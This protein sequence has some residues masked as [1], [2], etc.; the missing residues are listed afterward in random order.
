MAAS[1]VHRIAE[2]DR[3]EHV[4]REYSYRGGALAQREV[5]VR[6]P[7]WSRTGADDHSVEGKVRAWQPILERGGTLIGAFEAEALAG[8]AIYRPR[9]MDDMGNL[10][11]LHV[12]RNHRRKGVASRLAEEV[13]RLARADGALRLY[14]SAT[15]SG[16]AVAFYRSHGFEP[17]DQ[18]D[19]ALFA[20]EPDDIH[21]IKVL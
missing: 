20:L 10:S 19:E 9:L 2:I 15:P 13:A 1:E 11:V 7:N 21:M 16:S 8:F 4:T 18:P 17:T 12:S 3:S 5:D 14:V 6:V